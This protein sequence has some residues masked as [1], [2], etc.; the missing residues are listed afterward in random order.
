MLSKNGEHLIREWQRTPLGVFDA[1]FP[2]VI[3][4]LLG[5]YLWSLLPEPAR[6]ELNV[7]TVPS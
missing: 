4:I 6:S 5:I 3:G 7:I 2:G 1:P